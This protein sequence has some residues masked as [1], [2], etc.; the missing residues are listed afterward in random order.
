LEVRALEVRASEVRASEVRAL[1]VRASEA[2][3]SEVRASEVR[4]F[5]GAPNESVFKVLAFT[6]KQRLLSQAVFDG[7]GFLGFRLL[8]LAHAWLL[9]SARFRRR[10]SARS[11]SMAYQTNGPN[12]TPMNPR[13]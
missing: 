13:T 3:A 1:E 9:L 8:L 5:F 12:T 11:T 2:R 6:F 7:E 10:T 4:A